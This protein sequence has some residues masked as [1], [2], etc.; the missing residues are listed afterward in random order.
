VFTRTIEALRLMIIDIIAFTVVLGVCLGAVYAI[1]GFAGVNGLKTALIMLNHVY[2]MLV[3]T[4]LL[5]YGMFQLPMHVFSKSF[6]NY[7][8]YKDVAKAA[9]VYEA[10]QVC[11]IELYRHANACRNAIVLIRQSGLAVKMKSQLD[12]LEG[13]IPEKYDDGNKITNNKEIVEFE[14]NDNMRVNDRTLGNC[15]FKLMTAYYQYKR[16]K[17]RWIATVKRVTN[18]MKPFEECKKIFE[19]KLDILGFEVIRVVIANERNKKKADSS[20]SD[21]KDDLVK[22]EPRL[23]PKYQTFLQRW[24]YRTLSI[25]IAVY[26]LIII[27]AE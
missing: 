5:G 22:F 18:K 7:I 3:L 2:G 26:C 24:T 15:R 12:T 10:Y 1:F 20:L 8:F 23:F 13:S 16:K 11:Q 19:L 6:Q 21:D 14:L 4:W 17:A 25:L 9:S 27:S